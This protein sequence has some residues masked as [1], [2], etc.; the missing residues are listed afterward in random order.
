MGKRNEEE[1]YDLCQLFAGRGGLDR[2]LTSYSRRECYGESDR[3]AGLRPQDG[4][5]DFPVD[6]GSKYWGR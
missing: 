3:P 1:V 5:I 4:N 2:D 6:P